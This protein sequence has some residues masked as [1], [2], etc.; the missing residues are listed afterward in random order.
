ML[1]LDWEISWPVFTNF[2]SWGSAL[3]EIDQNPRSILSGRQRPLPGLRSKPCNS[4]SWWVASCS[5]PLRLQR[6]CSLDTAWKV[7]IQKDFLPSRCILKQLWMSCFSRLMVNASGSGF[8]IVSIH[9]GNGRRDF[10]VVFVWC[11]Y[12]FFFYFFLQSGE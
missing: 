11:H 1:L 3:S 2:P 6:L 12:Y 7:L 9:V 8:P 10:E 5:T 4:E